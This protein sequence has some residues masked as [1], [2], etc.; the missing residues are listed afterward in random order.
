MADITHGHDSHGHG[1]V[2]P[3]VEVIDH[4]KPLLYWQTYA[5]LFV[6]LIVTVLLYYI[7]L[8]AAM[9]WV[10]W[11]FVVAMIVASIKAYL[12]VRN[13]MNVKGS[14]KLTFLWAVLGFVWLMLMA[15]VFIDYRSRPHQGGWEP[16]YAGQMR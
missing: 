16:Q 1:P 9:K 12:V 10:G 6:L 5:G 14:T 8:S 7:D 3:A 11:N 13:F 15:G 4:P 2:H